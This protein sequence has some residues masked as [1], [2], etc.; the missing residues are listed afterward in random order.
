VRLPQGLSKSIARKA[1]SGDFRFFLA[2]FSC[3]AVSGGRSF[4]QMSQNVL[5]GQRAVAKQFQPTIGVAG[6]LRS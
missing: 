4:A 3:A 1:A 6:D 2:F 5:Y